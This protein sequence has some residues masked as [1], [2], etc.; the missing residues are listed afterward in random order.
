MAK[1]ID[2]ILSL[3]DK[4]TAPLGKAGKAL[5]AH[6]KEFQRAGKSI[7]KVGNAISGAGK[8]MTSKLTAPI[9]AAGAGAVKLAA[10]FEKGMSNV[11][12]ISGASGKQLD[13]LSAKAKEMG[14]KTKFS[15]LCGWKI[16]QCNRLKIKIL[17][18]I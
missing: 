10:D 1:T 11:Q 13:K 5:S 15:H 3:T 14:A 7:Q 9:A 17:Y 8:G 18:T 12:S 4:L 16:E 6:S 2:V